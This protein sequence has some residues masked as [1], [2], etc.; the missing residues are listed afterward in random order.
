MPRRPSSTTRELLALY[1]RAGRDEHN[2]GAFL[3][4][5]PELVA[6]LEAP[7]DLERDDAD[8]ALQLAPTI[9][10]F[11]RSAAHL[12]ARD[13]EQRA[14]AALRQLIATARHEAN[15]IT[16][17]AELLLGELLADNSKRYVT[18]EADPLSWTV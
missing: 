11:K 6:D 10:R 17:N 3:R 13:Q 15:S 18:F 12:R 7:L 9:G 14:S 2:I 4:G 1:A 16:L 8:L 5:R